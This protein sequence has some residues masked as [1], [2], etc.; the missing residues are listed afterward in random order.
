MKGAI[1]SA[2]YAKALRISNRERRERAIG[3][4]SQHIGAD[5]EMLAGIV[6]AVHTF[7]AEN[8][9]ANGRDTNRA[10]S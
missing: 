5:T 10:P 7:W 2:V 1:K 6:G 4:I 3:A 8:R 9:A